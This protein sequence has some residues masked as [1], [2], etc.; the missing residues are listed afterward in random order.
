MR[1]VPHGLMIKPN[2]AIKMATVYV[3]THSYCDNPEDDSEAGSN[4]FDPIS[5]VGVFDELVSALDA[6]NGLVDALQQ[7]DDDVDYGPTIK[8]TLNPASVKLA[9]SVE[10]TGVY[11]VHFIQVHIQTVK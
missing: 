2:G 7:E 3:V 9:F 11:A 8:D 10:V 4:V 1:V 6:A 5:F